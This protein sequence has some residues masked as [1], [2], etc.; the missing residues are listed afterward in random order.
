[1][2]EFSHGNVHRRDW[3]HAGKKR[4]AYEF[5]FTYTRDG[6][7]RRARGQAATRAEALE[8]M[9]ARKAELAREPEPEVAASAPPTLD[10]Y[11]D[12]W[13]SG[14]AS[15]VE[16]RTIESY[17]GMLKR[18]IRPTLGALVLNAITRGQVKDLLATKRATGLAK[19]TVRLIR[20]TLSALYT[21]AV[22]SELVTA[23]PA[24][25]TGRGR[26]PDAASAAER[27]QRIKAM[28]TQ[29]LD[30]FLGAAARDRRAVLWLFL[31]DTGVRPGE[32][33]GLRWEDVDLVA[34][35]AHIQRAIERGSR[36]VKSTKTG[37]TRHVDLTPRLVKM[38]DT[39]QTETER[40]ALEA[41]REAPDLVFPSAE[42]TPLDG[43]TVAKRFSTLVGRAGLPRFS[44]YD[45][46]HTY[47]S[48]LLALGAPITYVAAQLGHAKPT[49]TLQ[50]YAHFLPQDSHGIAERLETWRSRE[51]APQA[52]P[53]E[54]SRV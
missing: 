53:Q 14:I 17:A 49:M 22:D 44:I 9:E 33:L 10:E 31:V 4:S 35:T 11:A 45:T 37:T 21:D 36:R 3:E 13:L 54:E 7:T 51:V 23:N 48:H 50:A 12:R 41:G 46:R 26:T 18:H 8:A 6:A 24:A 19:S 52:G 39:L 34:R 16:P 38:L 29:Q 43:R 42:G 20:A 27:R 40:K 25:R 1:M 47:A 2:I 15:S 32:A 28:S 5:S 30:T